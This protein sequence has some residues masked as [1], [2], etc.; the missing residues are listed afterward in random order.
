V[1]IG[2]GR[3]SRLRPVIGRKPQLASMNFNVETWSE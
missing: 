3:L 2:F 1:V